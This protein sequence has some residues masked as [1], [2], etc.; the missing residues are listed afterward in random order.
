MKTRE[1]TCIR[2]KAYSGNGV[3]SLGYEVGASE[4]PNKDCPRPLTYLALAELRADLLC[5][6]NSYGKDNEEN[7]ANKTGNA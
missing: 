2:C 7:Y 4:A 6:R 5:E 3:C 1:K